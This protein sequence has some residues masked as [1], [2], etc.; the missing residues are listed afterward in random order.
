MPDDLRNGRLNAYMAVV[1]EGLHQIVLDTPI[2][3]I[4]INKVPEIL[5]LDTHHLSGFGHEFQSITLG[6][7]A[8]IQATRYLKTGPNMI[9]F[10]GWLQQ[11]PFTLIG[12]I[13]QLNQMVFD[14]VDDRTRLET[15][16]KQIFDPSDALRAVVSRR[17][18]TIW[19]KLTDDIQPDDND[20]VYINVNMDRLKNIAERIIKIA[21]VNYTVHAERYTILIRDAL[22]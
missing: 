3:D 6:A 18:K 20:M 11:N 7:I 5:Q 9:R 4:T 19:R 1:M 10:V 15:V 8:F 13:G 17:M 14:N 16:F 21:K 12:A 2:K 22:V